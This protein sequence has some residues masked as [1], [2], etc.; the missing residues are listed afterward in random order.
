VLPVPGFALKLMY[1]EMAQ[2]VT[3]GRRVVPERLL[4]A[5]HAF[6]YPRLEPALRA[7]VGH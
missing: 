4:A 3:E 2:V 5:G 1:G 6:A 7:A